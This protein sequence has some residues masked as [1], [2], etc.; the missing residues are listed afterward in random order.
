MSIQMSLAVIGLVIL[1]AIVSYTFGAWASI[2]HKDTRQALANAYIDQELL[3]EQIYLMRVAGAPTQG[4][5][6]SVGT[7]H[8]HLRL[9]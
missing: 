4:A 1:T 5:G 9:T 6:S 2:K 8:S 3:R 7:R